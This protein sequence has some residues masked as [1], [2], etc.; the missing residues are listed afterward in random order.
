MGTDKA[1]LPLFCT[2]PKTRS[3]R[4]YPFCSF[5]IAYINRKYYPVGFKTLFQGAPNMIR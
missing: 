2:A 1:A 3:L 5:P 4:L